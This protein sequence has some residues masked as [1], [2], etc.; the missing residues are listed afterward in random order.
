M[1]SWNEI[2]T[3]WRQAQ[4]PEIQIIHFD[5]NNHHRGS[6]WYVNDYRE[7]LSQTSNPI[8]KTAHHI[9]GYLPDKPDEIK[10]AHKVHA[11]ALEMGALPLLSPCLHEIYI[12]HD[13]TIYDWWN[14]NT[15]YPLPPLSKRHLDRYDDPP[16]I[17][18]LVVDAGKMWQQIAYEYSLVRAPRYIQEDDPHYLVYKATLRQQTEARE[19]QTYLRLKAKFEGTQ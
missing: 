4:I 18:T 15:K 5:L 19:Y 14:A 17:Q 7:Q 3:Y 9:L 12:Q 16:S 8:E 2:Y 11:Y 1:H 6:L 13:E 10:V